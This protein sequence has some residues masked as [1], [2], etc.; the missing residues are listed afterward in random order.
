MKLTHTETGQQHLPA[1]NNLRKYRKNREIK[2]LLPSNLVQ[3][4]NRATYLGKYK[5]LLYES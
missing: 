3:K 5:Q 4:K 1:T 2:H